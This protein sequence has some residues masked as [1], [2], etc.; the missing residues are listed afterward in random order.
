MSLSADLRCSFVLRI[1][2]ALSREV[3]AHLLHI[4]LADMDDR[5]C[6]ASREL[7]RLAEG[8]YGVME[9]AAT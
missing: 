7:A 9:T 8:G 1:L 4:T 5:A 2:A 6:V 3:C